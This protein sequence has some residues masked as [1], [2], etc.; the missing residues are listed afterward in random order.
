MFGAVEIYMKNIYA[1]TFN[2]NIISTTFYEKREDAIADL[3]KTANDRRHRMG[4]TVTEET[5]TTFAF[6]IGWEEF[7]VK[8]SIIEIPV[9]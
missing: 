8:F 1:V 2:N 7:H 9:K 3:K 4:V 6:I 5:E